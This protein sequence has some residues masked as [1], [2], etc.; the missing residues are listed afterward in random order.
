[1]KNLEISNIH[2]LVVE[3]NPEYLELLIEELDAFGY[4][5]I[6]SARDPDKAREKR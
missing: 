5:Y 6:E 2:I 3:D 1:M 4:Q